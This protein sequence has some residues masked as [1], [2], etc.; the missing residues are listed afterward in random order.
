MVKSLIVMSMYLGSGK[1]CSKI[2]D[3]RLLAN[4][5]EYI[6][7]KS[8]ANT[9]TKLSIMLNPINRINIVDMMVMFTVFMK[10]LNKVTKLLTA[11]T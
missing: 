2:E 5:M 9:V 8:G 11:R 4:C 6:G 3:M 7:S 1:G 10:E